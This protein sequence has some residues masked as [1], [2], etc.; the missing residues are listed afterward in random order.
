MGGYYYCEADGT[1][2]ADCFYLHPTT[3][4]GLT[5]WNINFDNYTTGDVLTGKAAGTPDLWETQAMAMVHVETDG[6]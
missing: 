4:I 1:K 3:A 2:D 6:G 5:A